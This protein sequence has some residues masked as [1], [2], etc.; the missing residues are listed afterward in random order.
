MNLSPTPY[1]LY[2]WTGTIDVNDYGTDEEKKAMANL[3]CDQYRLTIG[4]V[5][6][7]SVTK[8]E[9]YVTMYKRDE[10]ERVLR[11]ENQVALTT[12][13]KYT[14]ARLQP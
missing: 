8:H 12:T 6:K 11:D 2:E 7:F 10:R 9:I 14:K 4:R 5:V 3:I 13:T 1:D